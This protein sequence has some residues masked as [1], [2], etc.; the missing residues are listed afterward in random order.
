LIR[1]LRGRVFAATLIA[2]V[3]AVGVALLIGV[4]TTRSAVRDSY[5][6]EVQREANVVAAQFTR[7]GDSNDFGGLSPDGPNPGELPPQNGNEGQGPSGYENPQGGGGPGGRDA[8][9]PHILVKSNAKAVLPSEA[10]D[11]I[12]AG[13]SATGVVTIKNQRLLFAA[14]PVPSTDYYVLATRPD[15]IASGDYSKYLTGLIIAALVAAGLSAAAAA[16]L[17]SRITKPIKEVVAASSELAAGRTPERLAVPETSELAELAT[18]FND[19][20]D[21]L[22]RA[23]EAE[24]TVLM[25]ASHELR[26]PL[27]AISGYAEGVQDGTIDAKTGSAVIVSE[28]QRLERLVQ[29]LLVLARLEQGTFETRSEPVDLGKIAETARN[30]LALRADEA[31]V[32]LQ[33]EIAANSHATADTGRVLQIVT[34]LVDNAV[35]I[36]PA[37]GSVTV[38]TGPGKIVVTDTGPGIPADDLPHVFERFHLRKRRGMGSPDGSGIGLAIARELSEA[39]GGSVAVASVEGEGAVFTVSLPKGSRPSQSPDPAAAQSIAATDTSSPHS[40]S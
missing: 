13:K 35:R 27:T 10:A 39:M 34:N 31:K 24:R 9:L 7:V 15:R 16:L 1:S 5:R 40:A 33:T 26:T 12:V 2:S 37:G 3:A 20:A 36:T 30:R 25:S 32:D 11:H 4:F 21:Q 14:V 18:S 23:R 28:S 19:M 38:A 29:D 8:P 22:A 6:Q 17:A